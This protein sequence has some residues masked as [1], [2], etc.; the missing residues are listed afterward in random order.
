MHRITIHDVM[1]NDFD[2]LF[3]GAKADILYS[4]PPWGEGNLKFWRTFNNQKG[5][6][7]NWLEFVKRVRFLW[8]RHVTGA[9]FIETGVRFADDVIGMFGKP[10]CRYAIIYSSQ[11]LPNILLG[12]GEVPQKDPTGKKGINVPLTVLSSLPSKPLSVFDPCVGLGMTAKVAKKLSMTCFANELNP[13]RA[14]R[15]MKILPFELVGRD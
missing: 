7:V 8:Q 3:Q 4:D 2:D 14:E 15:T 10:S 6:P 11:S 9:C 1:T 13:K 5:H 12:W